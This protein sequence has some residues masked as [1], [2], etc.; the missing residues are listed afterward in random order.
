MDRPDAKIVAGLESSIFFSNL[1]P[2][3]SRGLIAMISHDTASSR[4]DV[5]IIMAKLLAVHQSAA[6]V[7]AFKFESARSGITTTMI[8]NSPHP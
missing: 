7:S 5:A 4:D 1:K 3:C 6:G 2:V 8:A